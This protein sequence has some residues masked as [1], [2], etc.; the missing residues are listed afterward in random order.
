MVKK[1]LIV[2]LVLFSMLVACGGA[3]S[4]KTTAVQP[5]STQSRR[6]NP[7][8]Q[9]TSTP[10]IT[11]DQNYPYPGVYPDSAYPGGYPGAAY[12]GSHYPASVDAY[13]GSD[14]PGTGASIVSYPEPATATSVSRPTKNAKTGQNLTPTPPATL[15]VTPTQT[16]VATATQMATPTEIPIPAATPTTTLT[17]TSAYKPGNAQQVA[18]NPATVK[19]STGRLQLIEFFAFWDGNSR[20][21]APIL[22]GMEN[23]YRDRVNFVYL[24]I[25][26]PATDLFKNQLGYRYQP[27][28]FLL[29]GSGNI[30]WQIQGYISASDLEAVI[31]AALL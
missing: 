28:L 20:A 1:Q 29:D 18:T 24:D 4:T 5:T 12:P 16:P 22:H 23:I 15:A 30:V 26:D 13:P 9:A 3:K 31:Q 6:N 25:N 10:V 17:P 21:M 27:H 14:Y 11:G 2:C 7:V 8:R 19:L